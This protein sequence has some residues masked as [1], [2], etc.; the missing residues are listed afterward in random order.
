MWSL[1]YILKEIIF[2][3]N[4]VFYLTWSIIF[5][6]QFHSSAKVKPDFE[7][8]LLL[9]PWRPSTSPMFG[10]IS[11]WSTTRTTSTT[12]KNVRRLDSRTGSAPRSLARAEQ[13]LIRTDR[14]PSFHSTPTVPTSQD[15]KPTGKPWKPSKQPKKIQTSNLARS[16]PNLQTRAMTLQPFY[17]SELKQVWPGIN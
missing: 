4:K 6:D 10:G 3:F 12:A 15:L 13:M 7:R 9:L 8:E 11:S 16:W 5:S 14:S 17:Q 2:L 1:K